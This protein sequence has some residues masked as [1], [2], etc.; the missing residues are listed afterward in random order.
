[1]YKF[2]SVFMLT[3]LLK[4]VQDIPRGG[5]ELEETFKLKKTKILAHFKGLFPSSSTTQ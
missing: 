2:G 5:F 4:L 1:M 3:Y